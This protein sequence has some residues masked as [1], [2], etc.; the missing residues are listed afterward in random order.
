[1]DIINSKAKLSGDFGDKSGVSSERGYYYQKLIAIYYLIVEGVR[2]IEYEA[3]GEDIV[4]I[5]EDSNRDCVEYIQ[6][7]YMET[8]QFTF[9]KFTADVFPQFWGAYNKALEKYPSK[10]IYCN[11]VSSVAYDRSLKIFMDRCIDLRQRGLALNDIERSMGPILRGFQSMKRGRDLDQLGRFMWGLK[12]ASNFPLE[13]VKEKIL[14]YISKCGIPEP[15]LKLGLIINHISEVGQGRITRRQIEDMIGDLTLV[16]SRLDKPIY[17]N[18][19]IN[20]YLKDLNKA[21]SS[22][23]ASKKI[24]DTEGII[25]LM[26]SPIEKASKVLICS[27]EEKSKIS[28]PQGELLEACDII[29]SDAQKAKEHAIAIAGLKR[30]LWMHQTEYIQRIKS[31]HTTYIKFGEDK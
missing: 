3:D 28:D 11:L 26:T 2:E 9:T 25:R 20:K 19:Q 15:Q 10:A 27:L 31:M 24:P 30:Q 29:K 14:H 18:T 1:M 22:Y 7:K 13:F 8:G 16:E 17:T 12:M 5:N 23:G 21:K 6:A 4:L